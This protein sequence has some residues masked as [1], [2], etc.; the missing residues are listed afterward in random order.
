VPLLADGADPGDD[1]EQ[2]DGVVDRLTVDPRMLPPDVEHPFAYRPGP[3]MLAGLDD[4]IRPGDLV[5]LTSR[6]GLFNTGTIHAVRHGGR[7]LLSRVVHHGD[8]LLVLSAR[9]DGAPVAYDA[10]DERQLR[11][12]LAGTVVATLRAWPGGSA[13]R[14]SAE[15]KTRARPRGRAV[16]VEGDYLVRDC[17]WREDYGWRPQQRP[18]DLDWLESHP[19]TRMR[20]RL[21][22]DGE[23]RYLLEMTPEQWR[24]ALGD[25][26]E[27]SGWLR[28][29]YIVAIT[30]RREGRYTEEF[31]E[32]WRHLVREA[33]D[34]E[35][36][37]TP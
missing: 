19:G 29:G 2:S 36:T 20:F 26:V 23:L 25:Y 17:E 21:I 35:R 28:N 10:K 6:P 18:E 31:Q 16:R 22:R 24:D 7:V 14:R 13:P 32:R 30:S 15:T 4:A 27:G 11:R 3:E 5:L 12:R 1:P 33:D 34:E 37:E 9:R 8:V